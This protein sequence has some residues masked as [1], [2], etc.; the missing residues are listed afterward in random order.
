M[1]IKLIIDAVL[2]IKEAIEKASL[3]SLNTKDKEKYKSGIQLCD[4]I[5]KILNENKSEL[6]E[7]IIF[8]CFDRYVS[9][10]MT[11]QDKLLNTIHKERKLIKKSFSN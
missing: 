6:K 7:V 3:D 8:S 9:D 1:N 5:I 4:S 10:S 2:R 11:W